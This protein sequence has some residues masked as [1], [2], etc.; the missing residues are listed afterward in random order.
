MHKRARCGYPYRLGMV[1]I[2]SHAQARW[3][4]VPIPG[5]QPERMGGV[6]SRRLLAC[7][8]RVH[9]LLPSYTGSSHTGAR[10]RETG[11]RT[12]G[13]RSQLPAHPS[14]GKDRVPQQP[15]RAL[16]GA[17]GRETGTFTGDTR[18]QRAHQEHTIY[19]NSRARCRGRRASPRCWPSPSSPPTP[20]GPRSSGARAIRMRARAYS[21]TILRRA[22]H[23]RARARLSGAG[24]SLGKSCQPC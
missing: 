18:S 21:N 13:T 11:T 20:T 5:T 2:C 7:P 16:P 12:G 22:R 14:L 19:I 4:W 3:E 15:S 6:G 8:V 10:G 1:Y 23:A 17:R 24:S 9:A